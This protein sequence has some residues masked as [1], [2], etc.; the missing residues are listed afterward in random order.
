MERDCFLAEPSLETTWEV[1]RPVAVK[2]AEWI[3][4]QN[5]EKTPGEPEPGGRCG[6]PYD[7]GGGGKW[8][9][10]RTNGRQSAPEN[11][12]L[13]GRECR[14]YA[15]SEL[16]GFVDFDMSKRTV[17]RLRLATDKAIYAA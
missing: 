17:Q 6:V 2:M 15:D 4:P 13:S 8:S 5:E 10:A 7:R 9:G 14:R 16:L 3:Y 1:P 12:R 11:A